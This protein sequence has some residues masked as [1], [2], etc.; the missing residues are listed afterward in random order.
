VQ[1][2]EPR[3]IK[4]YLGEL[5][6]QAASNSPDQRPLRGNDANLVSWNAIRN[7]VGNLLDL[8]LDWKG[9]AL[10]IVKAIEGHLDVSLCIEP[11]VGNSVPI[12]P[13][14]EVD[15][16]VP[17]ILRLP[18]PRPWR[19]NRHLPSSMLLAAHDEIV[20]FDPER[21]KFL[22][23]MRDWALWPNDMS[24]RVLYG[25]GGM[26]KT[27]IALELAHR[28]RQCGWLSLWL[29]A[30][31]PEDWVESWKHILHARREKPLLL[32][33]D[34]ADARQAEVLAALSQVLASRL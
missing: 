32:V 31:P 1:W 24:T 29:S 11:Q 8:G 21:E 15:T 33:I 28:L 27:R 7:C 22:M 14:V 12:Q 5:I 9:T 6:D 4:F 2:G 25:P 18:V 17:A 3:R 30:T 26:G 13:P 20:R 19:P 34:Y 23:E 10:S 16:T